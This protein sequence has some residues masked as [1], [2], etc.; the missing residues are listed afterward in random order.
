M[1]EPIQIILRGWLALGKG[2][3]LGFF[4]AFL[5]F[6]IFQL[7]FLNV[8]SHFVTFEFQFSKF[9]FFFAEILKKKKLKKDALLVFFSIFAFGSFFRCFLKSIHTWNNK[10]GRKMFFIQILKSNSSFESVNI[11][12]EIFHQYFLTTFAF[13]VIFEDFEHRFLLLFF[14]LSS[15]TVELISHF[16]LCVSVQICNNFLKFWVFPFWFQDLPF[17]IT[18]FIERDVL[19]KFPPKFTKELNEGNIFLV[20]LRGHF[21]Q[22]Q[23]C[24]SENDSLDEITNVLHDTHSLFT[25]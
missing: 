15:N 6:E 4:H 17:P 8:R 9:V 21:E 20:T 24:F 2:I 12:L 22:A 11:N 23:F 16:S 14:E 18:I 1:K 3:F 10:A 7:W 25:F 19:G 5:R 13:S